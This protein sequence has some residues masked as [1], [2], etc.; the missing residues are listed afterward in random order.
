LA[1]HDFAG[2][3]LAHLI[4]NRDSMA[5][6]DQLPDVPF[7]RMERHSAHRHAVALGKRYVQKFSRHFCV[8][9]KKLIEISKAKQQERIGR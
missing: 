9:E 1:I 5:G 4:A 3:R 2:L 6:F 8:F 7:G